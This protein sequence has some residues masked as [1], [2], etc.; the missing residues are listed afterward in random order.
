MNDSALMERFVLRQKPVVIEN[1]EVIMTP[2]I[3]YHISPNREIKNFVPR[4][5]TRTMKGED[6]T[7][8][9]VCLGNFLVDALRGYGVLVEDYLTGTGIFD[10]DNWK[11]GYYIYEVPYQASLVPGVRLNPMAAHTDERWLVDYKRKGQEY[12]GKIIGRFF[13]KSAISNGK[14]VVKEERD[15]KEVKRIFDPNTTVELYLEMFPNTSLEFDAERNLESGYWRLLVHG[16]ERLDGPYDP[17]N[18]EI[19]HLSRQSWLNAKNSC[20]ELLSYQP[21]RLYQNW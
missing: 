7:V 18:V 12:P 21:K 16:I 15:E 2:G 6:I 1:V 19:K 9:R 11:G 13:A 8:A 20:A 5:M 4:Q 10:S 17:K 3:G 14:I